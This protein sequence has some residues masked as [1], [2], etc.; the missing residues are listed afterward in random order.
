MASPWFVYIIQTEDDCLYTG[1]TTNL[2]RR[3]QQ[4]ISGTGAK[5]LRGKGMLELVFSV[6]VASRSLAS[7][8]EYKIKQLRKSAKQRFIANNGVFE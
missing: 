1:I 6:E 3:M 7:Q 8:L 5:Y 4:H 2:A